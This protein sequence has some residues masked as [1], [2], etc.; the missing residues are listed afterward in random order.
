MPP[1]N[2]AEFPVPGDCT[3]AAFTSAVEFMALDDRV[4]E[5][6]GLDAGRMFASA[7]PHHATALAW[8]VPLRRPRRDTLA[9]APDQAE[10]DWPA[11]PLLLSCSM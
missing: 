10:L 3:E 4:E 11:S 7:R 1:P 2:A 5:T 9:F 8:P 6:R